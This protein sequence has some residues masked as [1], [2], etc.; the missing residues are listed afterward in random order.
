MVVQKEGGFWDSQDGPGKGA[1]VSRDWI[2]G[3]TK[4]IHVW[5]GCQDRRT[6]MRRRTRSSRLDV[7]LCRPW[8]VTRGTT[9]LCRT[10]GGEYSKTVPSKP[11]NP[12]VVRLTDGRPHRCLP[13]SRQR[14]RVVLSQR[15]IAIERGSSCSVEIIFA[16]P[17]AVITHGG[18]RRS[19]TYGFKVLRDRGSKL[20]SVDGVCHPVRQ[21]RARPTAS[22]WKGVTLAV[23][24]GSTRPVDWADPSP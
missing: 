1:L 19:A 22:A 13:S 21:G 7:G 20:C 17:N 9:S 14:R 18:T 11:A 6:T 16:E 8:L 12:G 10:G 4:N 15:Q 23:G 2:F 24:T 5:W 3:Q